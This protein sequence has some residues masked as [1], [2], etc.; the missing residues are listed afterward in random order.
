MIRNS[1][2]FTV[3]AIFEDLSFCEQTVKEV[4]KLSGI[5]GDRT[6][7]SLKALCK[8]YFRLAKK[9]EYEGEIQ[10]IKN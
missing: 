6:L 4:A 9:V 7:L 1:K 8:I 5:L 3:Q 10:D 2:A